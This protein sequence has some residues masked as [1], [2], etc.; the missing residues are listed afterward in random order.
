[1]ELD[2]SK[3]TAN[4]FVVQDDDLI[5]DLMNI[6]QN[7]DLSNDARTSGELGGLDSATSR[8]VRDEERAQRR[9][10]NAQTCEMDDEFEDEDD[11]S[12]YEIDQMLE[13]PIDMLD[14]NKND[15]VNFYTYDKI[16]I[17]SNAY[18]SSFEMIAMVIK[19]LYVWR[20]RYLL[21][22][23]SGLHT[24]RR[25]GSSHACLRHAIVS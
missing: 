25:L 1:M 10:R 21:A 11:E 18:R 24:S 9:T 14:T 22:R 4:N 23:M 2:E 7:D 12:D 15:Q 17:K 5:D 19:L 20:L 3:S 8:D 13:K 6:V 16:Q